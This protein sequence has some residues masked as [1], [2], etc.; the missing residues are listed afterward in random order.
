MR[1]NQLI[2]LSIMLNSSTS[3]YVVEFH[4]RPAAKCR[5]RRSISAVG[6]HRQI[7]LNLLMTVEFPTSRRRFLKAKMQ[8]SAVDSGIGPLFPISQLCARETPIDPFRGQ[9]ARCR[10]LARGDRATRPDCGAFQVASPWSR[11]HV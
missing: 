3:K 7:G 11:A 8:F 9:S 2:I 5:K 1:F 6:R 4:C 10:L